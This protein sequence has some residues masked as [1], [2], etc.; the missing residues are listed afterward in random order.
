M[1][2][3]KRI[4]M[5]P[6]S[7]EQMEEIIAL[8]PCEELKVAYSEMLEGCLQHIDEWEWYAMWLIELLDGTHIGDLCFKGLDQSGVAE[9]GYGI[10]EAYQDCGYATEAVKA[11]LAW[12]FQHP[13]VTKIEAETDKEN[14]VSQK[15][16]AK[17][18]FLPNGTVGEEGPR[19]TL[20]HKRWYFCTNRC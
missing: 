7:R 13:N 15:V 11:A 14:K 8:E 6:A 2:E 17:N 1:I 16:L 12:A 9:I 5:Y 4:K 19:F 18:G 3:T 20:T 10:L